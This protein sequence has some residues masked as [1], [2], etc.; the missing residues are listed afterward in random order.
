MNKIIFS[1]IFLLSMSSAF[2]SLADT[3]IISNAETLAEDIEVSKII[4]GSQ[5]H[6]YEINTPFKS[7]KTDLIIDSK[8]TVESNLMK[9]PYIIISLEPISKNDT[10]NQWVCNQL[11]E[12]VCFL[13]AKYIRPNSKIYLGIF[14]K[15]CEYNLKYNFSEVS[16]FNLGDSKIFHLKA[17]DSKVF[18]LKISSAS[19]FKDYINISSF[20]LRMA[21]SSMK[22]QI[23]SSESKSPIDVNTTSNWIGGQQGI[24]YPKN[25]TFL[26][27]TTYTFRI[28]ITAQENGV[29]NLEATSGNTVIQLTSSSLR[30]DF[31]TKETPLCY[32]FLVENKKSETTVH[33]KSVNGNLSV[34]IKED[35]LPE[36][37]D[38]SQKFNVES[39]KEA[40]VV[41]V[42]SSAKKWFLCMHTEEHAYFTVH[43]FSNEKKGDVEGYKNL[44]FSKFL[45]KKRTSEFKGNV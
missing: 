16:T 3:S 15:D 18:E 28:E 26:N 36:F 19:D 8:L 44:L 10:Q 2:S 40:K 12:E 38:F 7:K 14:C 1:T 23:L 42:S 27:G 33:V 30:F 45:L 39:E 22:I 9:S 4:K 29:F 5:M 21:K 37:D 31:I 41:V 17:S 6:Y 20:N 35:G 34:F 25:F 32:S 43:I 11:G 24:I 13:P